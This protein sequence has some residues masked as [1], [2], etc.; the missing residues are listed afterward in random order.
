MKS[1]YPESSEEVVTL[2]EDFTQILEE[3]GENCRAARGGILGG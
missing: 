1:Q 3:E 2:V